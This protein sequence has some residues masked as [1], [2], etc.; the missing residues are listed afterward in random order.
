MARPLRRHLAVLV[1]S[2][3]LV[4]ASAYGQWS[5]PYDPDFPEDAPEAPAKP[6]GEPADAAL[7]APASAGPFLLLDRPDPASPLGA[8]APSSAPARDFSEFLL[9]NRGLRVDQERWNR[10]RE[11]VE[12]GTLADDFPPPPPPLVGDDGL[13]VLHGS[14]EPPKPPTPEVELPTYGTSL[15]ITGR[16]TIGFSFSEK[17]YLS[18][19]RTLGRPKSTNLIDIEQQLQLRMQGKVG[20]K[21]TVNVDYDDTKTNKQDIS[22]V[23]QGDPNEVVQNASFGDIDLSLPATEFVSY[24]KQLFGIRVDLKYKRARAIFIGSRTKGQTKA[25]Q[26]KGNTQL[27]SQDILDINYIRRRYYDL[28]FGDARRLPL[29]AGSESVY[30]SRQAVGQTNVNEVSRTVDDLSVSASTFTGNF[31]QL[32]RGVDYTVDYVKGILTFRNTLDPNAVVA[33]DFVDANARSISQQ[34]STDTVITTVGSGRLK[35]IKTFGDVQI[36]TTA[37]SGYQRELKTFYSLGRSQVMRDDGRGNFFLRVLDQNRNQVGAN[38]N[39]SQTYPETIEV[40]FENGLFQLK[41]PFSVSSASPTVPDPEVYAPNGLNKRIIQAEY[42]FR[43]K[44]FFL[45]PNL[46]LQS[47]VVLADGAKLTRNVDYFIDYE[48]GFLTFFNEDRI[49]VD[50]VVDVTYEV[51]PFAG[52]ATESLLG[53]RVSYELWKDKWNIGS[54]LLYQTGAKTPT[55]P[56]INELAKSLLV[57][58]AD[59]QFTNIRLAS[60]L[61]ASFGAELAQSRSNPNLSKRAIVENMEGVRQDDSASLNDTFWQI[62]RNPTV[63]GSFVV[64]DSSGLTVSSHDEQTL[65]INPNAQAKPGETQKVLRFDYNYTHAQSNGEVAVV[66]PFSP[67]GLDFSQKTVVEVVLAQDS[68]SNNELRVE[69]GGFDEDVDGDGL[70]DTEDVGRD[71]LPNTR[72][73]GEG[74]GLLQ[75]NEDIGWAY[76]PVGKTAKRFGAG[77]GRIDSEDLNRNGRLDS[78]DFSGAAFG[79]NTGFVIRNVTDGV[80]LVNGKLNFGSD[81]YRTLQ[82]SLASVTADTSRWLAVK[83]VRIAVRKGA[84]GTDTGVVKIARLAVTG[85]TWQRGQAGDPATAAVAKAQE[86]LTVTA[87]NNVDNTEYKGRAIQSAGGDA[88]QVFSDLYGSL[89]EL[90]RQSNSSNV[91]EQALQLSWNGLVAGA[92]VYTKRAF[93]RAIDVSQH[94]N[95][96]FLLFGNSQESNCPGAAPTLVTASDGKT[97]FLRAGSDR[98]YFEVQVPVNFCGWKK[99]SLE[100]RDRNGDQIPDSW[101]VVQ[102]PGGAVAVST[103]NPSLQQIGTFVAGVYSTVGV[104]SD[105]VTSRHTGSVYLNELFVENPIIR[106]GQAEKLEA[107]FTVPGWAAFGGKYRF[108]DRNYQTPTTLV[109]NQDNLSQTAYLNITRLSWLPMNFAGSYTKVTTPNTNAV[110]DLTNVV[111]LLSQGTVRTWNGTANG[112]FQLAPWPR[113]NLLHER[114]RIEYDELSSRVDDRRSYKA[115]ASYSPPLRQFFVPRSM[116]GDFQ[117]AKYSVAYES[118]RVRALP[119][120]FSTDE[121][122]RGFGARLAFEPWRGSSFNPSYSMTLVKEDRRDFSS[123]AEVRK[124]YPKSFQ[125]TA[126]FTSTWN[127]LPWFKPGVSYNASTLENNVLNVST[128]IVGGSTT[129]FDIGDIKTVNRNGAGNVSLSLSAAEMFAKT[130]LFRS[131]ALTNSYQTQDGD[132]WNN[133]ERSLD[134]KT[135]LWLRTPLRPTSRFAQRVNL[136]LRDTVSSNQRWSPLEA[137]D[138]KG[139]IESFKSLSLTNNYVKSIQRSETTGTPSKT[140]STTLPDLIASMGGLERLVRAERWA[141]SMQVNLKYSKRTTENVATSLQEDDAFG[142]DLRAI[143]R[144]RFDTSLSFNLRTG[145]NEDLRINKVTQ[146]TDHKDATLQTTFDVRKFRFTPKVDY[147]S[148]VTTLGTGQRS[149]DTTV[150]TP[151]MLV[152]ADL[153]LP[154]G[155]KLPFRRQVLAFTNRVIWTTTLSLALRESPITLNDNSKLLNVNTSADYEIAKNLRMTLN[156]AM[157]RLWHKYLKEEDFIS[158]QFGTVLTFQF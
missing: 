30:L 43:L 72:D 6:A 22:V 65:V 39:P 86:T 59:T 80:D 62:G 134:T 132:S 144:E 69:L 19:Q 138:L 100:Q 70:L 2:F 79:Y 130:K 45:E 26:F 11:K 104:S 90:K 131:F 158:Y 122:T 91:S 124:S 35:V 56:S 40:D 17:R 42:R 13:Y 37:E 143:I 139:R 60:W 93:A 137:Y 74:D 153:S 84:G 105:P 109:A 133:V 61:S 66:Y 101:V 147:Q 9:Q 5:R 136:T 77:N 82:I 111:S 44:T 50:S 102:G 87:V 156:G 129:V 142:T 126:G 157:S 120:N 64:T 68:A 114:N 125:Q 150:I 117:W 15:S 76:D 57:Y 31:V 128:F 41:S 140:I 12:T 115:G 107:N 46:V 116:D 25:K 145:S 53:G 4:R 52:N 24:N 121:L 118:A 97:F 141:K 155:L 28:T 14:T 154:K 8:A 54:T 119:G 75:P 85:N 96:A 94:K 89:E 81:R 71:G 135:A 1:A 51:A 47:E 49:K 146:T 58:E 95:L 83:Q 23:Y 10:V 48:S 110:G 33:V 152:R 63:T 112:T 18:D 127:I 103:G 7:P 67:T 3:A 92:T 16:K 113:L 108:V 106:V 123:G 21:I 38:L 32:S 29:V 36:A 34:A 55:T 88:S 78:Q 98:D 149:Q 27:I 148:D 151:S 73:E 99:V 20:P